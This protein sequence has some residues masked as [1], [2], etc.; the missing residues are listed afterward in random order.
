MAGVFLLIAILL[1]IAFLSDHLFLGNLSA[2]A[3]FWVWS[4]L[5]GKRPVELAA[6]FIAVALSFWKHRGNFA[7]LF[8]G[9]EKGIRKSVREKIEA[10]KKS[11]DT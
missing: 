5:S 8:A 11:S 1:V 7:R 10:R 9:Q 6:L 4:F 3:G 2:V